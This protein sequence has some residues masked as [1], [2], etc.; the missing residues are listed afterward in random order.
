MIEI[1]SFNLQDDTNS[2][3]SE[4]VEEIDG[5]KVVLGNLMRNLSETTLNNIREIF[6]RS[7]Q[8]K[9]NA[10]QMREMLET[11]NIIL[12]AQDFKALFAKI[13]VK[14]QNV[15]DY[16]L[17]V[18]Y[19]ATEFKIKNKNKTYE[20]NA[21]NLTFDLLMK[22]SIDEESESYDQ[23]VGFAFNPTL[24]IWDRP[25]YDE[26]EYVIATSEGKIMFWTSDVE[27]KRT[28]LTLM[29]NVMSFVCITLNKYMIIGLV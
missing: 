22:K 17:F 28:E 18:T 1:V 3:I 13:D 29:P 14:K 23:V 24:D 12:S 5:I 11:Y 19:L 6:Q 21:T 9:M 25:I 8:N 26:S 7:P 10:N 20:E 2:S 16:S 27:W 15:V 4:Q